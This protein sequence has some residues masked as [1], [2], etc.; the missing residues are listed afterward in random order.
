[1]WGL[2]GFRKAKFHVQVRQKAAQVTCMSKF[3]T[4]VVVLNFGYV[5]KSPDAS[6]A[7]QS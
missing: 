7:S 4:R 1:M 6:A 5:L 2:I 3:K